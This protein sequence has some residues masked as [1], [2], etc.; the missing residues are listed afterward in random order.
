MKRIFHLL[1]FLI[2]LSGCGE[3][4]HAGE[5]EGPRLPRSVIEDR[6]VQQSNALFEFDALGKQILFGDLHVHTTFSADAF[7]ASLPI[8]GG[9]GAHPPAD[10]CDFARYCAQLDFWAST[11]HAEFLDPVRWAEVQESVRSCD[12]LAGDD[13]SKDL[14]SF[15]GWEWTQIGNTPESHYGHK[16]V[17]LRE[18]DPAAVPARPIAYD[19]PLADRFSV[20]ADASGMLVDLLKRPFLDFA[21]RGEYFDHLRYTLE[22]VR[23]PTCPND[24]PFSDR[25]ADCRD[26]ATTPDLLFAKLREWGGESIVIPHGNTWG[27][28]TPPGATWDKQL[29]GEMHD[30]QQQTLIEIYS[31]HGNTEEYRAWRAAEFAASGAALC[32]E[33]TADYEPCCYRAGEIIR[34]RCQDPTSDACEADVAA[35]RRNYL[36]A[37]ASGHLTVP[38]AKPEHWLDCGQCRDCFLPAFN[39][40]PGASVQAAMATTRQEGGE[41]RRFRFGFLASSDNHTARPGTGYKEFD[42]RRTTDTTGAIDARWNQRLLN[43]DGDPTSTA[44]RSPE[45]IRIRSPHAFYE[46][47]RRTSFLATGGLVAVHARARTR[48]ALWDALERREVYGTSGP[49]ILLYFDLI[50]APTGA[51]PMGTQTRRRDLPRFRVQ[52]L[53]ALIQKPGCGPHTAALSTERLE[54][55]CGGECYN[56]G[57]QRHRLDRIEV[58]RI[59]PARSSEEALG[60]LIEDPWRVL[61]CR[62]S[63]GGCVVEFGDSDFAKEQRDTLYYV[64]AIQAPTPAIGAGGLRC[65]RD[66]TGACIESRPCYGGYKTPRTDDCLEPVEERAWSSPIFVDYAAPAVD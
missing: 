50:N 43:E 13:E 2:L 37:G 26:T 57:D 9:E 60:D 22:M 47:E 17:L 1:S 20:T 33:P 18:I 44:T 49:R 63:G 64:R 48:E 61:P 31:G 34:Q 56:P 3:R 35:A 23:V 16:N 11:E 51:L 53:G 10:A 39:H 41:D 21:N 4:R 42:R 24:L 58:V 30:G 55:L 6:V 12:A 45:E 28:Y 62:D 15:L 32:S 14:I 40:R 52:A 5:I 7:E 36:A 59:Q 65:E 54:R 66:E 46:S 8:L 27:L 25:R 19:A 29:E 38:G